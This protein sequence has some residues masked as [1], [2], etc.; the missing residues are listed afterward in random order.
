MGESRIERIK[1]SVDV[2]Q[3]VQKAK[4]GGLVCPWCGSGT[5]RNQTGAAKYNPDTRKIHCYA[6]NRWGDVLDVYM[7]VNGVSRS[8][9][10]DELDGGGSWRKPKPIE[11]SAT[12]ELKD[13]SAYYRTCRDRLGATSYHRGITLGTLV[14]FGIGY[15]PAWVNPKA[16]NT[17]PSPRLIVPVSKH[18]YLA[19]YAG[20]GEHNYKKLYVGASRPCF[21]LEALTK[22]KPVFIVEGELDAVSIEDVGGCAVGLGGTGMAKELL[23]Y[24]K[25]NPPDT[26]FLLALDNDE[27]G[28]KSLSVL[29]DGLGGLGIRF[30][31]LADLFDGC[32]D[33][34]EA[35]QKD[36]AGLERRVREA[37]SEQDEN[38]WGGAVDSFLDNIRNGS[39]EPIQTGIPAIDDLMGG[40]FMRKQLVVVGAAPAMGKTALVQWLVEV[41]AQQDKQ[42]FSC[43][44]FCFEMSKDQLIARSLSR[45]LSENGAAISPIGI[46]KG[47]RLEEVEPIAH[48]YSE[49]ISSYVAYNPNGNGDILPSS[50]LADVLA[51][52]E[53]GALWQQAHGKPAPFVVVDYLQ[54]L[55]V[56]GKEETDAIKQAMKALKS[57]AVKWNTCV[58]A[59][60]ANN[61]ESN[62]SGEASMF[63]GRGSSS[64]EYGADT[65]LSLVFTKDLKGNEAVYHKDETRFKSLVAVKGRF[66]PT[67]KRIDFEFDGAS[68]RFVM[69]ESKDRSLLV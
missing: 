66:V 63:A 1:Q 43:M 69:N 64:I 59:V 29:K 45:L 31:V 33:A 56:D 18:H 27:S 51:S 30:K 25:D 41:M 28:E 8:A 13:W 10:M 68:M 4:R 49:G 50:N 26:L 42:D 14:R 21:N 67:G 62:K 20:S 39:Y 48:W 40:G 61:R 19:R 58:I 54:L 35:L 17:T 57:Y 11:K 15:D 32:K 22:G 65:V 3:F 36:R 47:E 46:L 55:D 44:Y 24:V 9:A 16:P 34:N 23:K 7:A 2:L 60:V 38:P 12:E 5:G 52:M 37:M 6:C 53:R